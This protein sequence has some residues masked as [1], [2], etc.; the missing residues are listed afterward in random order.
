MATTLSCRLGRHDWMRQRMVC[1]TRG[2]LV[3]GSAPNSLVPAER[4]SSASRRAA[5]NAAGHILSA[6][7]REVARAYGPEPH[8]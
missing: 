5:D 3:A 2:A 4:L 8:S 6:R 7:R 1:R